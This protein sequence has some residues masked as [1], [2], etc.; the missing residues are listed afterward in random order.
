MKV[1]LCH[2]FKENSYN[3]VGF[4]LPPLGLGYIASYLIERGHEVEIADFNIRQKTIRWSAYDV[5][6]ISADT[7]RYLS[8]LDLANEAKRA[9]VKVI[10]GGPHVTFMDEEPL[11]MGL[12]DYI[13]RGEG[14]ETM[15]ELLNALEEDVSLA[16]IKGITFISGNEIIRT[17]DR[18]FVDISTL[19]PPARDIL[20]VKSYQW[21][22]MGGRKMTS[23]LTSRGCPYDCNF[24]SSSRFSGLR[25]RALNPERVVNEVEDIVQNYGFNGI[26][27]LDDNF[28]LSPERVKKICR[29][30]V[31]R[32]IDIY[33]WCFSRA[34]TIL[35]NEDMVRDM[36]HAGARY[37]FIGFESN[38][39]E[40]LKHYN[41]R[42]TTEQS[43]KAVR[44]LRSYGISTHASFIIGDIHETEEMVWS[45]IN[46]AKKL[47]PEAVQ[48][49]ILTPYP[50]TQLFHE[51]KDRIY[52]YD[53]DLY[54]CLH[55]VFKLDYLSGDDILRLLRKAYISFYLSPRRI[56]NGLLSPIKGRGIKISSILKILRGIS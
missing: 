37:V 35:R 26:A 13:V 33:W 30:I 46:F 5:I 55:P 47:S 2:P 31:K 19:P 24:C 20:N 14:E 15:G 41:K 28:T 23:I 42:I 56:I 9:D 49:S 50:G 54:E 44:L 12:A 8:A 11:R 29:L 53:W 18:G 16:N 4:V 21:L 3:K 40:T 17:P 34:D 22:E 27:F 36:A 52:T 25:W 38:Q 6:G 39:D 45:T 51:V 43:L 1:L 32:G 7:P 48:F 10:L